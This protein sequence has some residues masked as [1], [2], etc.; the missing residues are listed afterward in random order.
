MSVGGRIVIEGEK[1]KKGVYYVSVYG[2]EMTDYVIGIA[3]QRTKKT[4]N[5]TN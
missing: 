3:Y 2:Y 1:L 4:P 5:I